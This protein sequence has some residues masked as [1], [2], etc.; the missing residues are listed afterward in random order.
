M[1]FTGDFVCPDAAVAKVAI[2]GL[3]QEFCSLPKI[4]NFESPLRSYTGKKLT[5]GVALRSDDAAVEVL[6][7]LNAAC[8]TMA[9]NHVTDYEVSNETQA[10]FFTSHGI[11]P[12]GFGA[13]RKKAAEPYVCA[14]RRLMVLTFGWDVIRCQYAARTSLGVNPYIYTNVEAQV[15]RS[16]EEHPGY[17]LVIT[18]HWNYEFERYP[19]PADRE[20]AHHLIDLG[21]DAIIGHHP[22]VVS[23]CEE[24]RGKPIFYSLGNFYFPEVEYDGYKLS[25]HE[26]ARVGLSV[27][28]ADRT[29]N[30]EVF[31]HRQSPSG[32]FMELIAHEKMMESDYLAERSGFRGLSHQDYLSY[33]EEHKFHKK[34]F[35]PTFRSFQK[36]IENHLKASFVKLRQIPV[37][38]RS[39]LKGGDSR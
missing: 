38:L 3:G 22:H 28:I 30:V 35:L 21:V 9:N 5:K 16:R 11:K 39:N 10:E 17:Q 25:F 34:K 37:D 24:Y 2:Q 4:L 8:V 32:D 33:F 13:D 14:R 23:G 18:I 19:Q 27:K 7:D 1:I 15:A 20:F 29:E 12:I 26:E 36:P 31:L 6:S